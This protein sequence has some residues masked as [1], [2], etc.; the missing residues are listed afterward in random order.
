MAIKTHDNRPLT[1][2]QAAAREIHNLIRDNEH[3]DHA[4]AAN[5]M[6]SNQSDKYIEQYNQYF[7]RI[8]KILKVKDDE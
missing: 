8:K 7:E 1:A 3:M 4:I 6:T 2:R 5:E